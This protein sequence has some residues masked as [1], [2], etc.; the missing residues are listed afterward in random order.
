MKSPGIATRPLL[1]NISVSKSKFHNPA[2]STDDLPS[3]ICLSAAVKLLPDYSTGI[4]YK[5][6]L[7]DEKLNVLK[8]TQISK[9]QFIIQD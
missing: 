7:P 9:I 6:H 3:R 5:R 4:F 2:N 1:C 8:I